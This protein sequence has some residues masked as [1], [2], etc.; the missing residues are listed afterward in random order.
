MSQ[1]LKLPSLNSVTF[2]GRLVSDPHPL[3]GANDREG[4]ALTIAINR[5][6]GRGKEVV[7]TYVDVVVFGDVATACNKFLGRGSAVLVSG[8]LATYEKRKDK[9]PPQKVLQV[10]ASAIEFLSPKPE[11][12]DAPAAE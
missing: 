6:T 11:V 10:S 2:C 7:T 9:G 8:S 1:T 3:K 4:S 12:A 5:K